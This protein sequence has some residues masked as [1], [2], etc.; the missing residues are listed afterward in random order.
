MTVVFSALLL[1]SLF[2]LA[3]RV[4][5]LPAA[6]ITTLLLIASPGF[7]ELSASCMQEIP[8]LAP[9][10]LC[11]LARVAP[12]RWFR[13]EALAGLAFG[14]GLQMKLIGIAAFSRGGDVLVPGGQ[15]VD[16]GSL[17]G[18]RTSPPLAPRGAR[19]T[20]SRMAVACEGW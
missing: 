9:I 11:V 1:G 15:R 13:A 7:I 14:F 20:P 4:S 8:A 19:S 6:A 17:T 5:G 10:V 18:T 16:G 2:H 12:G 3:L